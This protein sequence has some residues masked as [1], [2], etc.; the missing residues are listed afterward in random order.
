MTKE[1]QDLAWASLPKEI[2]KEI[3]ALFN[4]ADAVDNFTAI[5]VFLKLFGSHNLTSDTELEELLM[6]ERKYIQEMYANGVGT[7]YLLN[8]FDD[9]CLPDSTVAENATVGKEEPKPKFK[10]GDK[11]KIINDSGY[12]GIID[13][14]IDVGTRINGSIYYKLENCMSPWTDDALEPYTEENKEPMEEKELNLYELLKGCEGTEFWSPM[15]DAVKLSRIDIEDNKPLMFNWK[16]GVIYTRPNGVMYSNT[17]P[18][19]FPSRALYEKYPLD[20]RAA[21]R[22]WADARKVKYELQGPIYIFADGMLVDEFDLPELS[23]NSLEEAKQASET[24]R[25]CLTKFHEQ[26]QK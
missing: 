4:R 22:E 11:V 7:H 3:K 17:L 25:E 10:V 8:L 20:A 19:I 24:V 13:T 18:I 14:I 15:F 23:F 21:W 1:Q 9:K 5:G 2:R 26:N 16:D 6:V 12:N